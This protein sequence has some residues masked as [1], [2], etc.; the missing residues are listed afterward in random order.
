[1]GSGLSLVVLAMS[2]P[3]LR[4]TKQSLNVRYTIVGVFTVMI[5]VKFS[6]LPFYF[7]PPV[8]CSVGVW[9]QYFGYTLSLKKLNREQRGAHSI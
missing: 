8:M 9:L 3:L 4:I 5:G 1:M 2:L 6:A 7:V